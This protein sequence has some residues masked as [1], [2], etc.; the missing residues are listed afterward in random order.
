MTNVLQLFIEGEPQLILIYSSLLS[1]VFL[2]AEKR[3][4]G[5]LRRTIMACCGLG[6]ALGFGLL[7]ARTLSKLGEGDALMDSFALAVAAFVVGFGLWTFR[8]FQRGAYGAVEIVFGV[9]AAASIAWSPGSSPVA[10][11]LALAAS[12]YVVVRGLDNVDNGI[13][14]GL[15]TKLKPRRLG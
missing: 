3:S 5:V 2:F 12:I 10:N 11:T 9:A 7:L 6:Q 15:W 13:P 8:K 14:D 4:R 1:F